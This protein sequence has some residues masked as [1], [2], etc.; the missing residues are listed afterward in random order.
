M[1]IEF[2]CRHTYAANSQSPLSRGAYPPPVE[3][4]LQK[5]SFDPLRKNILH[6]VSGCHVAEDNDDDH[7]SWRD[8]VKNGAVTVRRLVSGLEIRPTRGCLG[9]WNTCSHPHVCC[10]VP[11][12]LAAIQADNVGSAHL[13]TRLMHRRNRSSD[14][15]VK[16]AVKQIEQRID[17][18]IAPD[19]KPGEVSLV[20]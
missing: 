15:T 19:R 20:R 10:I 16:T 17:H 1:L 4:F 9:L 12:L 13:G 5:C 18:D 3:S 6:H 11:K 7:S 8:S 2:R 14:P